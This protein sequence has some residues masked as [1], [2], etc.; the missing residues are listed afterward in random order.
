MILFSYMKPH[1]RHLLALMSDDIDMSDNID[2]LHEYLIT[3]SFQKKTSLTVRYAFVVDQSTKHH[4]F[5]CNR[6]N[7][8][9]QEVMQSISL[10]CEPTLNA[11]FYGVTHLSDETNRQLFII[12]QEYII[13]QRH[14]ISYNVV[15]AT[16][17]ASDQPAHRRSLIRAFTSRLSIL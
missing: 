8:L 12:I 15:C 10:L 16:I 17:K 6:F 9:R 2:L 13:E 11:L 3:T 14:E 1:Y 7:K 5:D 4:L